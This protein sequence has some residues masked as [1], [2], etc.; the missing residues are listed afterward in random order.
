MKNGGKNKSVAFIRLVSVFI[1]TYIYNMPIF[2]PSPALPVMPDKVRRVCEHR[3]PLI[4]V[5]PLPG[6]PLYLP[7]LQHLLL[8]ENE[9]ALASLWQNTDGLSANINKKHASELF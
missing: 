8:A 2:W 7:L 1:Y 4:R 5:L 9:F 3:L 6:K